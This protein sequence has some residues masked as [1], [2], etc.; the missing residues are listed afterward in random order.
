MSRNG[1]G[2][3]RVRTRT[4]R[5]LAPSPGFRQPE[6]GIHANRTIK[7]GVIEMEDAIISQIASRVDAGGRR[8]P[9]ASE[10]AVGAA[11]MAL[12]LKIPTLLRSIYLNVANGGFGPGYG[13]LGVAGGH[14]SG[15]GTALVETF[16]EVKRGADY[17]G[18][19]WDPQLLPFCELGYAGFFCV[20]C[21]SPGSP[22][23]LS[24][25]CN[26]SPAGYGLKEFFE[27]WLD[28]RDLFSSRKRQTIEI[29]NPFTG[30]KA[31]IRSA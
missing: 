10:E 26:V 5:S 19:R 31:R 21:S 24:D 3:W 13:I 1:A 17:R 7:D 11:E 27:R 20:R 14:R 18:W 30:K 28:A 22:I 6:P 12:G 29:I 16:D 25:H 15:W 23:F 4:F 8:L 9:V 2:S